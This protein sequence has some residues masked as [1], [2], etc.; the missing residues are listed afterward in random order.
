MQREGHIEYWS[1]PGYMHYSQS[2]TVT[3]F[4]RTLRTQL[5]WRT[6]CGRF[7]VIRRLCPQKSATGKCGIWA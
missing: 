2:S 6:V 5:V 4:P 7:G 3:A 1:W